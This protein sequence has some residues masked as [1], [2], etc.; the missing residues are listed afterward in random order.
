MS[1][2]RPYHRRLVARDTAGVLWLY[3]GK[4]DG[5]F[6]ARTK[7]GGGWNAYQHLVGVG[8]ADRDGRPDLVG[9]GPQ[10]EDYLYRGTG[11]WKT[12]FLGREF[13]GLTIGIGG[14]YNSIA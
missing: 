11:D 2:A 7:I 10:G 5:T 14:P 1:H 8:D 12:P 6:A 9:F 3:L 13:A 4:G